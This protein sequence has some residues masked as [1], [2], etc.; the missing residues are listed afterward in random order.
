MEVHVTLI[1]GATKAVNPCGNDPPSAYSAVGL[2]ALVVA[3][4]IKVTCG[5]KIGIVL[6]NRKV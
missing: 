3:P 2:K 5:T 1:A 4:L 6:L